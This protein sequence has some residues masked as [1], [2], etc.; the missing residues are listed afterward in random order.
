MMVDTKAERYLDSL[1][2]QDDVLLRVA[3][4]SRELGMPDIAVTAGT[5]RLLT[6]LAGLSGARRALEIGTL[7][8]YSAI[9]IARG[10]PEDGHLTTLELNPDFARAAREHVQL[11]GL[12]GKVTVRTGDAG[13]SLDQLA[14]EGARFGFFFI[15]AD[16]FNYPRYLEGVLRLAEP[17]ALIVA[18]NILSRGRVYDPEQDTVSVAALRQFNRMVADD[19]RLETVLLPVYDGL[20]LLRIKV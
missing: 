11:A 4:H 13:E 5:G 9:C 16:K 14:E 1:Y 12:A 19:E 10:L 18:D 17:G 8:G 7:G 15:D 20:A 3:D 6:W 2:K